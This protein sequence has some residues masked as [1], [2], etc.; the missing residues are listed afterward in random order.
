MGYVLVDEPV[1]GVGGLR[2]V[3]R[4]RLDLVAFFHEDVPPGGVVAEVVEKRPGVEARLHVRLRDLRV[5]G[6]REE[7]RGESHAGRGLS[8]CG[9]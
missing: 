5:E 2:A 4:K 1:D 7:C 9:P 8:A 6:R 3:A